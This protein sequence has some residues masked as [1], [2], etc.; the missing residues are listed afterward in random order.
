VQT[1]GSVISAAFNKATGSSIDTLVSAH[2]IDEVI[3]AVAQGLI[4]NILGGGGI[5]GLSKPQGGGSDYFTQPDNSL[6]SSTT[7][8]AAQ[9]QDAVNQEQSQIAGYQ[10]NWQTIASS[11]AAAQTSVTGALNSGLSCTYAEGSSGT[12]VLQNVIEPVLDQST[13]AA[14]N[15]A[16]SLSTLANIQSSITATSTTDQVTNAALNYQ[17]FLGASTTP[18]AND[19]SYAAT[20]ATALPG[21]GNSTATTTASGSTLVITMHNIVNE[22]NACTL[23]PP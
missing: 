12:D 4:Q 6:A 9:L 21:N 17:Q 3:S 18:S 23:P 15:A 16:A 10:A 1:P 13:T 11:T 19:I 14:A 2:Q 22:V 7:A 5:T 8:I 20:Q